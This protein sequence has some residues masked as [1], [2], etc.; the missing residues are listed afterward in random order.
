MIH[1][2]LSSVSLL[3]NIYWRK[4]SFYLKFYKENYPKF[5][6]LLQGN[7]ILKVNIVTFA[8]AHNVDI[9]ARFISV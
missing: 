1:Y 5:C 9:L 8:A 2:L 7:F 3:E 6:T 4:Y